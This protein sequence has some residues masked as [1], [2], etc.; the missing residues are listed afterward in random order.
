MLV[1]VNKVPEILVKYVDQVL[2]PKVQGQG[3]L[4]AFGVGASRYILPT[5]VQAK[6][7]TALPFLQ[8]MGLVTEAGMLDLEKAEQAARSGLKVSGKL[9]IV[10]YYFDDADVTSLVQIAKE[11]VNG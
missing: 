6:L 8:Q 3:S 7:T 9:S 10:G 11:Y 1:N 5:L 2:T 4:L